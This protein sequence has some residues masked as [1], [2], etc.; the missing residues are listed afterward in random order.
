[1]VGTAAVGGRSFY[2]GPVWVGPGVGMYS[3]VVM[4]TALHI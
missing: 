1:M 3:V 4:E 2:T